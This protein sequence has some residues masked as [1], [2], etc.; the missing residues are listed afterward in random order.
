MKINSQATKNKTNINDKLGWVRWIAKPINLMLKRKLQSNP[1]NQKNQP[2]VSG[3]FW[4]DWVGCLSNAC[5]FGQSNGSGR[6]LPPFKIAKTKIKAKCDSEYNESVGVR[7]LVHKNS[8]YLSVN[9]KWRSRSWSWNE[10]EPMQA[11]AATITTIKMY[12]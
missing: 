1:T 3:W 7:F 6:K 8:F 12:L 5:G 11:K 4:I 9:T 2:K 10:V